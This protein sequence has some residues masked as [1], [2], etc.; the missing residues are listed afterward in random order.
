M[1]SATTYP[2]T[3]A[4]AEATKTKS[5]SAAWRKSSEKLL[6]GRSPPK[7]EANLA[8]L[9]VNAKGP[10]PA[11]TGTNAQFRCDPE[12]KSVG[13]SALLREGVRGEL[14]VVPLGIQ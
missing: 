3:V 5:G 11:P 7:L 2:A 8:Q 9:N 14:E 12:M 1:A 4:T 10:L 6:K 13:R